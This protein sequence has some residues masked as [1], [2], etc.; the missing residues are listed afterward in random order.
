MQIIKK[1]EEQ[2]RQGKKTIPIHRW[3]VVS[4]LFWHNMIQ[5]TCKLKKRKK[6]V[7]TNGILCKWYYAV[8][9][10]LYGF[11]N[12]AS[13]VLEVFQGI[14]DFLHRIEGFGWVFDLSVQ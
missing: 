10:V 12:G 8:Y 2:R 7:Y 1:K 11:L 5:T 4:Y 9:D 14:W 6:N 3:D 13:G